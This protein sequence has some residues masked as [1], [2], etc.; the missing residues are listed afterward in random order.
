MFKVT[1]TLRVKYYFI[2]LSYRQ[3]QPTGKIY[4]NL[5]L[6]YLKLSVW[7]SLKNKDLF[8][9]AP[10]LSC[11]MLKILYQWFIYFINFLQ[12]VS[13]THFNHFI[14]RSFFQSSDLFNNNYCIY[15][16]TYFISLHIVNC[17]CNFSTVMLIQ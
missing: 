8:P 4:I 2:Q 16:K 15:S 10:N 17:I 1:F 7:N 14:N 9:E 11:V 6:R 12:L 13:H 3:C 5:L